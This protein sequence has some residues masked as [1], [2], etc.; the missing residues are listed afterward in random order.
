MIKK[1]TILLLLVFSLTGCSSM[2]VKVLTGLTPDEMH[3]QPALMIA[4]SAIYCPGLKVESGAVFSIEE[5]GGHEY[6]LQSPFILSAVADMFAGVNTYTF[7]DKVLLLAWPHEGEGSSLNGG[8][9]FI[10][11]ANGKFAY[12]KY[13]AA[14]YNN[15]GGNWWMFPGQCTYTGEFPFR[16]QDKR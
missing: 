10:V 6:H 5:I 7:S 15:F 8:A 2:K 11:Y 12:E 1:I 14:G 3:K 16:L 13:Y 9:G 4:S